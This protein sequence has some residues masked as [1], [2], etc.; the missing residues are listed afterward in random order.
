LSTALV[1]MATERHK[2]SDNHGTNRPRANFIAQ[3]IATAVAAPQTRTRR[4][5]EPDGARPTAG[6]VRP[7]GVTFALVVFLHPKKMRAYGSSQWQDA[8]QSMRNSI[9]NILLK[10]HDLITY[11]LLIFALNRSPPTWR[12][13]ESLRTKEAGN[14]ELSKR[15]PD[16]IPSSR[17]N[18]AG[19]PN[20]L[21]EPHAARSSSTS[22]WRCDER[23]LTMKPTMTSTRP[24]IISRKKVEVPARCTSRNSTSMATNRAM[25]RT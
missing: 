10:E 16:D 17:N 23:M 14:T 12:R 20:D 9:R 19:D 6:A 15:A 22:I 8:P 25:A 1:P 21:A 13:L 11:I 2:T 5:A 3:L 24:I 7:R 4:R 18:G